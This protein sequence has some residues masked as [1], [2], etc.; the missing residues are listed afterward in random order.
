[1][2]ENEIVDMLGLLHKRISRSKFHVTQGERWALV[3]VTVLIKRKNAEIE[4]LKKENEILSRN[5]D[6][7]FQEGLN[8]CRELFEHEIKA[9]AYKEFA[10]KLEN[11]INCRTTLSRE[12]DKN[13][14]HIMHNLLKE[15]VG[16]EE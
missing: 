7:A 14:I 1:M 13:V 8:E 2:T 16:E 4:K 9:D 12:Q 11:E 5:A 15:M 3:D 10:E 6:N